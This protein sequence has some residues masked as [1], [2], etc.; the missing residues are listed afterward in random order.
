MPSLQTSKLCENKYEVLKDAQMQI[1]KSLISK[2]MD[3][4][5]LKV[6]DV[7]KI[8]GGGLSYKSKSWLEIFLD[9]VSTKL[10]N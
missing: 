3:F 6:F 5:V 2:S 4:R 7:M 1:L 9:G 10:C 8:M